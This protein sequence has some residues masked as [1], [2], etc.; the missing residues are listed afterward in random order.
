MMAGGM[1]GIGTTIGS[2]FGPKGLGIGLLADV[3]MGI[4]G[5]LFGQK[6]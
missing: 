6:G 3:G 2:M 1:G 4:L 5:N